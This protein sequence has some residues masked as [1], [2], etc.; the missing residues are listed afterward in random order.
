MMENN[1]PRSFKIFNIVVR[2]DTKDCGNY[3]MTPDTS[4]YYSGYSSNPQEISE[5]KLFKTKEEL[6]QSL[7]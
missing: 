2:V 3:C 4:V 7:M 5:E 1:R 6:I